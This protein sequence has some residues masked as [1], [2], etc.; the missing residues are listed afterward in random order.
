MEFS[1]LCF[2]LQLEDLSDMED[3]FLRRVGKHED[4]INVDEYEPVQ[5]VPENIVY[6]GLEHSRGFGHSEWQ[7]QVFVVPTSRARWYAFRRSNLEK[8]AAP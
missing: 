8:M 1:F 7:H 5:H 3:M 6:R 2:D 4:V